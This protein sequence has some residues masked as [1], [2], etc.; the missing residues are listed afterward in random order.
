MSNEEVYKKCA[1]D[2]RACGVQC[3]LVEWVN[4]SLLKWSGCVMRLQN[5][6]FVKRVYK[7][8]GG[9]GMIGRP[10]VKQISRTEEFLKGRG[11]E[12]CVNVVN[13]V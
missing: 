10:L 9:Q 13:R 4:Q 6:D 2:V 7:Y 3:G 5:V 12:G 8:I 11:R 1:V